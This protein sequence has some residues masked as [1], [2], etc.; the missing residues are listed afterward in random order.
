MELP[1]R[2]WLGGHL[3]SPGLGGAAVKAASG[4]GVGGRGHGFQCLQRCC[5]LLGGAY[6]R[7]RWGAPLVP[8]PSVLLGLNPSLDASSPG[9]GAQGSLRRGWGP[10][11]GL[12]ASF[13]SGGCWPP[14]VRGRVSGCQASTRSVASC[15]PQVWDMQ[16]RVAREGVDVGVGRGRGRLS[17]QG[18]GRRMS[19]CCLLPAAGKTTSPSPPAPAGLQGAPVRGVRHWGAECDPGPPPLQSLAGNGDRVPCSM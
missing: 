17:G 2:V 11:P 1:P 4:L 18:G 7:T 14:R 12:G 8:L 9:A 13:L 19:L 5:E 16:Q 10:R 15:L 3:L 6:Q